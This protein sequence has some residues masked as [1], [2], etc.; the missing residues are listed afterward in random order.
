MTAT[1]SNHN[2]KGNVHVSNYK[3]A[4]LDIFDKK[5]VWNYLDQ[6][7]Q[8]RKDKKKEVFLGEVIYH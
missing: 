7:R 3:K 4:L 2:L 5:K 8:L 6:Q 1:I